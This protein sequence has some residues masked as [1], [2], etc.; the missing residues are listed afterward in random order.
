MGFKVAAEGYNVT[1][2][3]YGQTA[4]GKTYTMMGTEDKPGIIRLSMQTI[5]DFISKNT[6]ET[7]QFLIRVSYMEI[8]NEK[9]FD[10]LSKDMKMVNIFVDKNKNISFDNLKEEVVRDVDEV[11]DIIKKGESF[12]TVAK[13]FAN[14]N[15]SRSHTVFRM[16][17]ERKDEISIYEESGSTKKKTIVRIGQLN[18]VDLAGSE[19]AS[20]HDSNDRAREG[21]NINLSLLHLKEII[22]KLSKGKKVESFRNSKLTRIL[23]QS[24]NG[25]AKVAVICAINPLW[26]NYAESKQTL[27]FGNCAG[28]ISVAPTVN[29]DGTNAM[30]IKYQQEIDSMQQEII[31]LK[32]KLAKYDNENLNE[33]K[34]E[35]RSSSICKNSVEEEIKNSGKRVFIDL[36]RSLKNEMGELEHNMRELNQY[37]ISNETLE[38]RIRDHELEKEKREERLMKIEEERKELEERLRRESEQLRLREEEIELERGEKQEL[39][40]EIET[41]NENLPVM[42]QLLQQDFQQLEKQRNI[43]TLELNENVAKL[44]SVLLGKD[45]EIKIFK[46]ELKNQ[47][48]H[49]DL[50][51]QRCSKLESKLEKAY[52]EIALLKQILQKYQVAVL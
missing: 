29:S 15:S 23:G 18:L 10:L 19:N 40:G 31:I 33:S 49:C 5:F 41:L 25:N 28:M 14:D 22:M 21:K 4:S 9:V 47:Q 38:S 6:S 32:D 51:E 24:L 43:E 2:F 39:V 48:E 13:T 34:E 44:Y 8:Y 30:I 45:D 12:R 16:V 11:M 17:I 52:K 7:R 27:Y 42:Y 37:I 46:R 1:T 20:K 50:L 35:N 36:R 26:E 3:A